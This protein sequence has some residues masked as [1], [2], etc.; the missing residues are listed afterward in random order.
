MFGAGLGELVVLWPVISAQLL[1][2]VASV[3]LAAITAAA[4]VSRAAFASCTSVMAIRPT[5][6]R[7]LA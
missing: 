6:K 2:S 1:A 4:A 5:S 7:L 3:R